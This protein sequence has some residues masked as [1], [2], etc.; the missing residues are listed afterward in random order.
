MS[1]IRRNR[2][3]RRIAGILAERAGRDAELRHAAEVATMPEG[4]HYTRC[5]E[6]AGR[7]G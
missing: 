5:C 1:I 6:H 3:R 7:M 4:R 2:L